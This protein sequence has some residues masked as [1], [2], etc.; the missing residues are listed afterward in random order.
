MADSYHIIDIQGSKWKVPIYVK[1]RKL[2]T[3]NN[4]YE[5]NIKG[6]IYHFSS[7]EMVNVLSL[8]E[9]HV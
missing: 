2:S 9:N 6:N 4:T 5:V 8:I 1:V 7:G 3:P